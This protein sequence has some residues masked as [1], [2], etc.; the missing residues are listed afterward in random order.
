MADRFKELICS[1]CNANCVFKDRPNKNELFGSTCDC[2]KLVYCKKC[3]AI[4]TSEAH[5][6][7]LVERKLFFYCGNCKSHL[8]NTGNENLEKLYQEN[9]KLQEIVRLLEGDQE[10]V[11]EEH[12]RQI[13]ELNQI[14][15]GKDDTITRMK[16]RTLDFEDDVFAS[17]KQSERKLQE[18]RTKIV[19]LEED[20][21]STK[22]ELLD[23]QEKIN[24]LLLKLQGSEKEISRLS[25]KIKNSVSI[26]KNSEESSNQK[27]IVELSQKNHNLEEC[28]KTEY[29]RINEK[30][31]EIEE[32]KRKIVSHQKEIV[33]YQKEIEDL[34]QMNREMVTTIRIFEEESKRYETKIYE[35]KEEHRTKMEEWEEET[36]R[37][38]T[39]VHVQ[40]C[41]VPEIKSLEDNFNQEPRDVKVFQRKKNILVITDDCGK[42]L[43]DYLNK[44]LDCGYRLQ[45]ICK[46]HAKF[47]NII[48]NLD[49][50]LRNFNKLDFV[51]MLG[52]INNNFLRLDEISLLVNKCFNTNLLICSI[53]F[54][55]VN[56]TKTNAIDKINNFLFKSVMRL[57]KFTNMLG[58]IEIFN[59][60]R[61]S[62]YI[63]NTKYLSP[64]GLYKVAN[65]IVR[66]IK[67]FNKPENKICNLKE[68]EISNHCALQGII[69]INNSQPL[70]PSNIFLENSQGIIEIG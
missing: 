48:D 61:S 64:K 40:H 54:N 53:P 5:T 43:Y 29:Q 42:Y 67:D 27:T 28:L 15:K 30:Q 68:I 4:S 35:M 32:L 9:R 60:L 20:L 26:E 51:V 49:A 17:E 19:N 70:I 56:N 41:N 8:G 6:L 12:T 63:R 45:V 18:C 66:N 37:R 10:D 16:R 50:Y 57:K 62:D 3:A 11:K 58:Y 25:R 31:G 65:A 39:Y 36:A 44:Y 24:E 52:G 21:K 69:D 7:A 23:K 59:I 55:S 34:L 13:H 47:S 22:V 33:S 1:E 38:N 46:P 2:C 14:I